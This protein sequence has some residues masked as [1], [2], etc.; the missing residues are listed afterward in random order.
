MEQAIILPTFKSQNDD[1]AYKVIEE[2][3][4]GQTIET[5]ESSEIAREGGV[6]NCISWNIKTEN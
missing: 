5:I 3:F 6:L 4:K 2:V 1:K